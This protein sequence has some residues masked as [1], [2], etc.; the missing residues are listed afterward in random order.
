MNPT[1]V[2]QTVQFIY[3]TKKKPK[4]F[5]LILLDLHLF[6]VINQKHKKLPT[7]ESNFLYFY[8]LPIRDH[9]PYYS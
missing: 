8:G 1:F 3:W 5:E 7:Y 6:W 4:I 9:F 2:I